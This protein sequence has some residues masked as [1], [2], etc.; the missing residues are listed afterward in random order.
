MS[1]HLDVPACVK[2]FSQPVTN[3]R[4]K[5]VVGHIPDSLGPV[6]AAVAHSFHFG[7][8]GAHCYVC[9]LVAFFV[10]EHPPVR[11]TESMMS[12]P[13]DSHFT[14]AKHAS[15]QARACI[16]LM[17]TFCT[18]I[19]HASSIPHRDTCASHCGCAMSLWSF[20]GCQ[21]TTTDILDYR[22]HTFQ[23]T[24]LHVLK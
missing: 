12:V 7:E 22:E 9:G 10:D 24:A 5:D 1:T 3:L 4:G 13:T 21:F 17:L 16:V 6:H 18:A 11:D 20:K 23:I 19:P 14:L 15:P 2:V 8:Y